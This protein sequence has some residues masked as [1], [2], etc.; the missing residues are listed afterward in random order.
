MRGLMG[1]PQWTA[2]ERLRNDG[3]TEKADVFS[4]GVLTYEVLARQ[5]PVCRLASTGCSLL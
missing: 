1:S 5:L 4:F 2:P 3:C